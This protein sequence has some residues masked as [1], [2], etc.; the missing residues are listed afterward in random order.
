[1]NMDIKG[2]TGC[3]THRF[4][5]NLGIATLAAIGISAS[6]VAIVN[7]PDGLARVGMLEQP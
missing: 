1:M 5:M 7:G 6:A 3:K 2:T 4:R